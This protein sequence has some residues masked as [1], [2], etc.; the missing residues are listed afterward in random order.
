MLTRFINRVI[1]INT[2]AGG[3][4]LE[5]WTVK[6]VGGELGSWGKRH[7][8]TNCKTRGKTRQAE[9]TGLIYTGMGN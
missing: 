3:V 4:L 6:V 7:P 5:V 2:L 8:D 9:N 1:Y